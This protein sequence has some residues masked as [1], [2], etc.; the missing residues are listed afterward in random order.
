MFIFPPFSI[1]KS[2]GSAGSWFLRYSRV[3]AMVEERKQKIESMGKKGLSF[4]QITGSQWQK[5]HKKLPPK[6]TKQNK[7]KPTTNKRQLSC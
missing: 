7:K 1:I 3:E 2:V 4:V 6:N 5:N